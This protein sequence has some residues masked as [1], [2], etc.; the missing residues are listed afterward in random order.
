MA[1]KS[2]VHLSIYMVKEGFTMADDIMSDQLD[3]EPIEISLPGHKGLLYVRADAPKPPRWAPLFAEFVNIGALGKVSTISGALLMKAAGRHFVLAFGPAGRH[4]IKPD[5]CEE[6]F[7]LIVALNTVDPESIRVV[8][9]QSLDLIESHSRIQAGHGTTADQFGLDVE[10]DMLRSIVGT[11]KSD[12]LGSRMVGSEAL[13][14]SVRMDLSDLPALLK[15]YKA[16]FETELDEQHQW[17]NNIA[18]VK[19]AAAIVPAL[20][21]RLMDKLESKDHSHTW[22][23]IPEVIDWNL[24]AGFIYAGGKKILHPDIKLDGFLSTVKEGTLSLELLKRR[25]V[26]CADADH[27]YVSKHWSIFKCLYA[28]IDYEGHKYI[29]NAGTWYRVNLDFVEQTDSQFDK[30]P[31]A[32]FTLPLYTGGGEAAYNKMVVKTL[33]GEYFLLDAPNTIQHGGPYGKVE[34][35]DL[36]SRDK[37]FIHVKHYGKS[38]VLS[39]LF[40]QG[41]T[42]GRLIQLDSEFRRKVKKKLKTPFADLIKVDARPAEKEFTVVY[43]IISDDPAEKLS[44]PFF[45]RVNLNNTVKTLRGFGYNVE[46]L[47]ISWEEHAAKKKTGPPGEAK[48]L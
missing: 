12:A 32:Q 14:V 2:T 33:P 9:K 29:L 18:A 4:L 23:S 24:V 7:G 30:L 31:Y 35:C 1:K 6:R 21:E 43:G 8:D 20:E 41:L 40:A 3:I 34:A 27:N 46:L 48:K 26:H 47:K 39:H 38:S 44:L 42:S 22:L 13:G 16:R 36:F 25:Q 45:S 5:V 17:V 37:Q 10:Q 28:E 15:T 11:P 19:N